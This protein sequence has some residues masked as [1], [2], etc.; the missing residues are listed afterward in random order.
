MDLTTVLIA[1]GVALFV[2]LWFRRSDDNYP[3]QPCRPLPVVGHLFILKDDLRP[4]FKKWHKELGDIFSLKIAGNLMVVL[5]SYDLMKEVLLKRANEFSD[6]PPFF[7]DKALGMEQKGIIFSNG[8]TWKE[9]RTVT[10]SILRKFGMG[11]NVLEQIILEELTQFQE[12]ISGLKGRPVDMRINMNMAM[13]NITLTL[14]LGDRFDY[15]DATFQK[16]M[17]NFNDVIRLLNSSQVVHHFPFLMKLPGDIFHAK[18]VQVITREIMDVILNKLIKE[19][20]SEKLVEGDANNFVMA[21][22]AERDRKLREGQATTMDEENLAKI[23]AD[24]LNAGADTTS[25]GMLWCML[26]AIN[27]PEVQEKIFREIENEIGLEKAPTTQDKTK[28]VYLNAFLAEVSRLASVAAHSFTHCCLNETTIKGYKIPKNSMIIPNLDSVM[29]DKKIWG[30]DV[31][32]FK[33]ERFINQ[34]GKLQIPEQLIPFGIGR[35]MCLG[36]GLANVAIFLIMASLFQR[37]QLRPKNM[38]SPPPLNY[39]FGPDVSPAPFEVCFVDRRQ[40]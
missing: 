33:P 9:Q 32:S 22:L 25:T 4:Q 6:R 34:E 5:N 26:Y 2:Y 16:L 18:R 12:L 3:P 1:S 28:L 14:L 29:Y 38:S 13:G 23:F 15:S 31:M 17:Q 10:L 19:K 30:N 39:I 20:K 21:Y 27:F 8:E 37:F 36:E 11:K 7:V 40:N 24:V 35:R